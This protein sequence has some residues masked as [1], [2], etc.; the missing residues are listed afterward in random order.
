LTS[1]KAYISKGLS[2]GFCNVNG[3]IRLTFSLYPRFHPL[4]QKFGPATSR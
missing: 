1:Q 3:G 2:A 4:S